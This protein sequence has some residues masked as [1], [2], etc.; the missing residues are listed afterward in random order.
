[1][2]L[3]GLKYGTA[4]TENCSDEVV[5]FFFFLTSTLIS[6]RYPI[7]LQRFLGSTYLYEQLFSLIKSSEKLH[8]TDTHLS[9]LMKVV[10]IPF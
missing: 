2:E 6:P 7:C 4:L 5:N 8:L 1:M 3:L 9:S 10:S